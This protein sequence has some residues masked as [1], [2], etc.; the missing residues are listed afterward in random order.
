MGKHARTF[1]AVAIDTLT[2]VNYGEY[3][4]SV[5][6]DFCVGSQAVAETRFA[7]ASLRKAPVAADVP[8]QA[9]EQLDAVFDLLAACAPGGGRTTS[10]ARMADSGQRGTNGHE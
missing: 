9:Q 6:P 10:A 5:R 4:L 8:S 1:V 2:V 7:H 3:S